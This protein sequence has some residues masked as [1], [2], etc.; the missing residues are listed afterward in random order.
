M[1]DHDPHPVGTMGTGRIE[2]LS[3]GVFAIIMTLLVFDIGIPSVP[4]Q[5][6]PAA[7]VSLWPNFI[8][9]AVSFVLLGI[10]WAGHRAQY[11]YILHV[12]SNLQWLSLLFFAVSGL[13]PFSTGLVSRYPDQWLAVAFYGMNLVLIGVALYLH[14]LYA[15]H[16]PQL[17]ADD[18]TPFVRRFAAQRCLLAPACYLVAIVLGLANP[19]ISLLVFALVPVLYIVPAFQRLWLRLA[20][21]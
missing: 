3:D 8:G 16:H 20:R 17:V 9:Y 21:H 13:V 15:I 4:P 5:E 1:S 12:D 14:W 18:L 10:Y 2:A 7:M 6:L 19:L 11:N